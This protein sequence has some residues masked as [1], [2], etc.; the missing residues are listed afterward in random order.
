M[1]AGTK[2]GRR[3]SNNPDGRPITS[4]TQLAD[5][6]RRRGWTSKDLASRIAISYRTIQRWVMGQTPTPDWVWQSLKNIDQIEKLRRRVE[7]QSRAPA[8]LD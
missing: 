4:D 1:T 8:K 6:L 2:V 5:E 3:R 7:R